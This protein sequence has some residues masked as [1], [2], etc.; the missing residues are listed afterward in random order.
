MFYRGK[1]VQEKTG[2]QGNSS[3]VLTVIGFPNPHFSL[4]RIQWHFI[5]SSSGLK[6]KF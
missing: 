2:A 6:K 5:A 1:T 4:T 3:L